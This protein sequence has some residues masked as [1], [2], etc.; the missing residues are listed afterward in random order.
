VDQLKVNVGEAELECFSHGRGPAIVLVPGGSLAVGYLGDLAEALADAGFRAVRLN[1]RGA[2]GSTGPMEG[3]TLHDFAADIAGVIEDLDLAPAV[4][5]GHA[6][7]NRVARTVAADRPDLVSAVVLVAAGGKVNPG[8]EAQQ[9]LATIFTPTSSEP[10][11]LDAMKWMVGSPE[12]AASVWER[13]KDDRAPATAGSQ[14]AAAQ[15]TPLEDWWS[16]PGDAPYLAIQGLND[17]A[18]PVENGHL[19]KE[20]LGDRVTLVDIPGAG[21]LQPLEAPGPVADAII[22]FVRST[23]VPS[24]G[25]VETT[26]EETSA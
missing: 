26:T 13:F 9:A 5:L 8:P 3:L 21:H 7:G 11:I 22:S 6:Y 4:V 18:A 2:G 15:A 17:A 20:E 25:G 16:P 10:E 24:S 19:L 12:N 23:L 14:M 1:P